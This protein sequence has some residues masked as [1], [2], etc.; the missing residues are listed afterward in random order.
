MKSSRKPG[1]AFTLNHLRLG[2]G[3]DCHPQFHDLCNR[4]PR[5][6][7]R[8]VTGQTITNLELRGGLM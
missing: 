7:P 2:K 1:H 6:L 8:C 3:T 4:F 5:D